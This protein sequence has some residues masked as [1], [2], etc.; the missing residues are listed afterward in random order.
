MNWSFFFYKFRECG[1]VCRDILLGIRVL[2]DLGEDCI[3]RL[4]NWYFFFFFRFG[5]RLVD[6]VRSSVLVGFKISS[7]GVD[8][9]CLWRY[10]FLREFENI[11]FGKFLVYFKDNNF[12][13]VIFWVFWNSFIVYVIFRRIKC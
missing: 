12:K 2:E 9:V 6:K 4:F 8:I 11:R 3:F 13:R 7:G 10:L 1:R 5:D